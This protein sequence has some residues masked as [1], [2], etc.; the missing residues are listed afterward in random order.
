MLVLS[1]KTQ[2]G[3]VI[4]DNVRVRVLEIRGDRV[5]LGFIAPADVRICR[6]EID[7]RF[8]E[9]MA[10]AAPFETVASESVWCS[11]G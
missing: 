7:Q 5:K 3:V 6:E 1:R 4:G 8:D 2:E 9:T 10:D 11:V